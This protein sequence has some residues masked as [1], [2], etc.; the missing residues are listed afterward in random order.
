MPRSD[1][2]SRYPYYVLGVLFCVN[3]LNLADRQVVYILFPL[4][5]TDLQLTDTQLGALGALPFALF[6]SFMGIPLGW[7]AD[8]WHRIRLITIGLT[9]WS[10]LT[11][12]SGMT[13]GFWSLFVVRVGVGIGESSCAPAGQTIL[14]DYFPPAK[15][16]TILAIF[17]CGVPIGHGLGLYLGG[18]IAQHW[19]WRSAFYLLGIPGLLFALL[20]ATLREPVRGQMEEHRQPAP[21]ANSRNAVRQLLAAIRTSP[22]LRW[23]LAGMALIGFAAN[24]IAIWLPTFLVR[25]RGMSVETAGEISG[26]SAI[27]AGLFGTFLGGVLA[28]RWLARR[29]NARMFILAVRNLLVIPFLFGML[30]IPSPALL[31]TVI[32]VGSCVSAVWFGPASAV[33]HDLVAPEIRSMAVAVYVLVINLAAGASPIIVGKLTDLSGDPLFLQYALLIAPAGDLLAAICHYCGSRH[34]VADM[35]ARTQAAAA[36]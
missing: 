5:K 20:V 23:H 28:D 11:A 29:K 6:Y 10:G 27:V 16:S 26:L 22:A 34:L 4:L 35:Q 8:R 18:Y 14:S 33:M 21:S 3:V 17:N 32:V 12:L 7:L 19:G 24:G 1:H 15:R 31:I 36:V 13:R 25:V 30:F 2:T 9:I